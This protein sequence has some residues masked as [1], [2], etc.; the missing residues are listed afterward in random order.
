MPY[1]YFPSYIFPFSSH[2]Y[3]HTYIHS[4]I[5]RGF[6]FYFLRRLFPSSLLR[7]TLLFSTQRRN[8]HFQA[9]HL[10]SFPRLGLKKKK[11]R[12]H[13]IP[14]SPSLAMQPFPTA[15]FTAK[16][17]FPVTSEAIWDRAR[18]ASTE[19]CASV[20]NGIWRRYLPLSMVLLI[21]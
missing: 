7:P 12:K 9:S 17:Y 1:I 8:I 5:N 15:H 11:E 13:I 6:I 2:T 21:L 3:I 20:P 18:K 14:P 16:N 19:I 10:S 4:H